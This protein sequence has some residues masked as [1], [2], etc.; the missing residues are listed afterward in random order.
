MGMNRRSGLL[1]AL[2]VALVLAVILAFWVYGRLMHYEPGDAV[3]ID[4]AAAPH[5][6]HSELGLLLGRGDFYIQRCC[7]NSVTYPVIDGKRVVFF[8][9]HATDPLVKHNRRAE[10]RLLSNRLT[11]EASY[12][13]VIGEP[14]SWTPSPQR[15]LVTQWHGT[16][17]FFLLEPGRFPP[18]E[19][20][21]EGDRWIV[22]KA[23]DA[24][25][26]SRDNGWG[27]TQ[28]R[29]VIGSAPFTPGKEVD[30]RFDVRWSTGLDGYVRAYKDGQMVVDDKGPN[31]FNDFIGPYMKFGAYVPQWRDNPDLKIGERD[32]YVRS[33]SMAQ[34]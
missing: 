19:L 12:H 30:W 34:H 11:R 5:E 10:A 28:G 24:R 31:A 15:V 29:K 33:A 26:R 13:V 27:N 14:A 8:H 9:V 17:D 25:W 21:I 6:A 22:Y 16:N 4:F 20:V 2:G 18:M 3:N 1:G 23:W 32:V 7:A